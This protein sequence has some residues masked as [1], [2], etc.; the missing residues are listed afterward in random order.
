M[1]EESVFFTPI[2][3]GSVTIPNRFV[4]SATHDFMATEEGYVTDRQVELFR[5]LA[6]GEVGLIIT[7]H[8]YV[9]QTGKAS[10]FQTAVYDDVF[11]FISQFNFPLHFKG[12]L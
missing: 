2:K 1:Q 12:V 11:I 8:A 6:A 9:N 7:G 3:I 5:Y 4:R 10:L